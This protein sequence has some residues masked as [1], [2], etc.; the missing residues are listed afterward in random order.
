MPAD[1]PILRSALIL[2]DGQMALVMADLLAHEPAAT[3]IR[4]WRPRPETRDDVDR[5]KVAARLPGY[6]L[7]DRVEIVTADDA[8]AT[9]P[10]DLIVN[11]IPTQFV[12]AV[13]GRLQWSEPLPPVVC[14]AKGIELDTLLTPSEIIESVVRE[15]GGATPSVVA[16]SGPNIARELANRLPAT[17]V[18]ATSDAG[19]AARTQQAFTTPWFRV[20]THDD[21]TGVEIAGA[22]KNVIALAAGMI[23]GLEIG[24]NAKSALLARGLAEIARLG[25]AL[26]ARTETFFGVAGVGDLATTCFCPMGRNRTCGERLGRGETL[27]DIL[28]STESVVEGVPTTKAI[29]AL[30]RRHDVEMPIGAAVHAILYEGL[31]PREA[32]G[33]LMQRELKAEEVG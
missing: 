21:R 11:A 4:L 1:A 5:T 29:M 6:T 18:A 32:I 13:W 20:Y 24:F 7:P 3:R 17:A 28:D 33:R 25:A 2:G 8:A 9:D 31:S 23:D 22:A 15:R 14:V 10:P 19:L 16:V 30:A 12:R 26:G 27:Q